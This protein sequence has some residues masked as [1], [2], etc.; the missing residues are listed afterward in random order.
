[1]STRSGPL[2]HLRVL[3]IESIG[4]GPFAGMLLADLGADVIRVDRPMG[5]P[6]GLGDAGDL[7]GRGKRS[8][9]LDLKNT[10]DQRIARRLARG[11][12]VLI[13]G[14][15]PGVMER[16]GLGPEVLRAD[17]LRLVYARVTGYGQ[18]G[19]LAERAGHDANYLALSGALGMIGTAERSVLPHNLL[20]DFGGGGMLLVVGVLAALAHV[21]RTGEG[22]VVDAS[23][24]DGVALLSTMTYTL[25]H[26]G[27]FHDG[28]GG[29]L[30]DG[31]APFYSIYTTRCGGQYVLGAVE[32]QFLSAFLQAASIDVAAFGNPMDPSQWPA[33]RAMLAEVFT[34]KSR[35]EWDALLAG[36]DT[37]ASPVLSFAEAEA[38]PHNRARQT[39]VEVAGKIQPNTAPR[40]S[41]TPGRVGEAPARG[42]NREEILAELDTREGA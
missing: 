15:R 12:D 24:V 5:A 38:H 29:N 13:E 27:L 19:P 37:C 2:T 26:L 23:M 31:T 3:E 34:Q 14:L 10:E 8:I 33:Q 30:F 36:K 42:A 16:L 7:F 11:V 25:K 21:A 18:D 32:P 9:T 41:A 17:N 35:A 22:Q 6:L 28:R 39:Y 40:F 1:M 4:P 20:A